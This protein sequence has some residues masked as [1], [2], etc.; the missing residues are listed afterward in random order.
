MQWRARWRGGATVVLGPAVVLA[1]SGCAGEGRVAASFG[2]GIG[3]RS[4]GSPGHATAAAYAVAIESPAGSV[5]L[6]DRTPG[7]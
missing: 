6:G 2:V 5:H 1:V 7:R 3:R 4:V